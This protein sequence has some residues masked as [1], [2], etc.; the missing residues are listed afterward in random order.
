MNKARIVIDLDFSTITDIENFVAICKENVSANNVVGTVATKKMLVQFLTSAMRNAPT[1]CSYVQAMDSEEH[2]YNIGFEVVGA[3]EP[4]PTI[5]KKTKPQASMDVIDAMGLGVSMMTTGNSRSGKSSFASK[6]QQMANKHN[7]NVPVSPVINSTRDIETRLKMLYDLHSDFIQK[8]NSDDNI[9]TL[10]NIREEIEYLQNLLRKN[11]T[12]QKISDDLQRRTS[13][14]I[15]RK[16][17][18]DI[19]KGT[20]Q[21]YEV[22][23]DAEED[24][25]WELRMTKIPKKY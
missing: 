18:E 10:H 22:D 15:A 16:L 13:Y 19:R 25:E 24:R 1:I 11:Q 5:T 14:E 4:E 23:L 2:D 20:V 7:N 6:V 8:S 9:T 17:D 3:I 21:S 12:A